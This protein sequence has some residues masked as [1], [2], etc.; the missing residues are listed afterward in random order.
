MLYAYP[1]HF[2]NRIQEWKKETY[3]ILTLLNQNYALMWTIYL[4]YF[5]FIKVLS[6]MFGNDHLNEYPFKVSKDIYISQSVA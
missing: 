2:E 3:D 5:S 4:R 6:F 1:T